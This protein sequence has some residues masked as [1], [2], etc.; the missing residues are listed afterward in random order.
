MEHHMKKL[1][2]FF[3][4]CLDLTTV[5][6]ENYGHPSKNLRRIADMWSVYLETPIRPED[7]AVLMCC[8]K[9][10]RLAEG[11]HQDS[12]DDAATYLGL[13]DLVREDNHVEDSE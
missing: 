3:Q 6:S 10:A 12:I 4:R 13:A 2:A 1:E 9:L 5:R 11:W 8:L 7:V